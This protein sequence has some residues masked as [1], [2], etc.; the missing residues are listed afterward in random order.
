MAQPALQTS[1]G[2]ISALIVDD[3]A[4][5]RRRLTRLADQTGLDFFIREA[6]TAEEFGRLLDQD[7]FDVI[8][9]DLDLAGASGMNLISGARMHS[10]NKNAAM[11]M[12]SGNDKAEVALEALRKGF[13]DY[14]GKETLTAAALERATVN[15]LQKSHLNREVESANSE[16]RSVEAVLQSF[17]RACS[18][19]MRPM[20]VRMVRQVRQVKEAADKMGAGHNIAEIESTCA[21]MEEFFQDLESLAKDKKLRDVAGGTTQDV[22]R[23]SEEPSEPQAQAPVAPVRVKRPA[24]PGRPS[25]FPKK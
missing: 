15:A 24:R 12:I 11:I 9:V 22:V 18:E 1:P 6:G 21:R 25:L 13:A 8:F 20:L 10:I 19:E 5:D 3:N 23:Y 16:T 7:K 17:S 2:L 14:I 4:F